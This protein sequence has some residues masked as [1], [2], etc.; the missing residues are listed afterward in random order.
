MKFFMSRQYDKQFKEDEVKYY[1]EHKELGLKKCAENLGVNKTALSDW[2]RTAR[3]HDGE[4]PVR[5]S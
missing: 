2:E 5:G 3:D 1:L 4:V